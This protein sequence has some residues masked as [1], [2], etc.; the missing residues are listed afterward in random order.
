MIEV[1]DSSLHRD[2]GTKQRIYADAGIPQYVIVNL[3]EQVVEVYER[4][5][6]GTG[7]DQPARRVHGDDVVAFRVGDSEWKC[8]RRSCCPEFCMRFTK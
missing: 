7:K 3:I 1:A 6:S 5:A 4:A 2:R 8:R